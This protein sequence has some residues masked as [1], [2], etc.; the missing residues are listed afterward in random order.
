MFRLECYKNII[1][2]LDFKVFKDDNEFN[3]FKG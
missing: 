2:K 1:L 3:I